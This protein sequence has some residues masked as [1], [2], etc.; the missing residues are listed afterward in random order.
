ME[1]KAKLRHYRMAP[2]K[3]RL[4]VDLVR[5][6]DVEKALS[7]LDNINKKA[8]TPIKKLL[9]SAIAN[10]VNNF[11]LEK[12]NL[13]IKKVFVDQ[14]PALKRWMPKAH[15]RATQIKKY[16]S[17][18]TFILDEKVS[19]SD[20]KSAKDKLKK[21]QNIKTKKVDLKEIK[22][23]STVKG[24]SHSE[25]EGVK[26]KK[27]NQKTNVKSFVRKMGDK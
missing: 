2:R 6:L 8:S 17:H 3:M 18:V 22:K 24:G 10:A 1:V 16:T 7:Q 14:G 21:D 11:S 5:G 20:K 13:Y 26:S 12:D 23:S 19:S 9:D 25:L 4:V 27:Q 15:G